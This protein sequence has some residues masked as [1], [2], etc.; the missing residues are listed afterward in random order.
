MEIRAAGFLGG[1]EGA[2]QDQRCF[3][4][5]AIPAWDFRYFS[6][7]RE[8]ERSLNATSVTNFQGLYLLQRPGIPRRNL[9]FRFRI[10]ACHEPL[11]AFTVFIGSGH[12]SP[13]D[14]HAIANS[15]GTPFA[16]QRNEPPRFSRYGPP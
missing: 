3:L 14:S 15:L 13:L 5:K 10:P 4:A 7:N 2:G 11:D 9:I 12:H 16:S 6:K 1:R 8:V